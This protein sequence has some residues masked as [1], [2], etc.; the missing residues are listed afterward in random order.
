MN[1]LGATTASRTVLD[2]WLAGS[3]VVS[4]DR[5]PSER[6]PSVQL[7]VSRGE[8]GKSLTVLEAK[9]IAERH[10]GRGTLLR[11]PW[12]AD[13]SGEP[14]VRRLLPKSPAPLQP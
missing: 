5:L 8:L 1:S 6:H 12:T 11:T 2:G 3:S 7:R 14:L 10:V 13:R 4:G 9:G